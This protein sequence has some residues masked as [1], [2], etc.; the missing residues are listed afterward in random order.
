MH[1]FLIQPLSA[2]PTADAPKTPGADQA[3]PQ[4]EETGE[5]FSD[6]FQAATEDQAPET[7]PQ[8]K[9]EIKSKD[10]VAEADNAVAGV[11]GHDTPTKGEDVPDPEF[12]PTQTLKDGT[13]A[14][15]TASTATESAPL[16][17]EVKIAAAS[18]TPPQQSTQP[19][20]S[21]GARTA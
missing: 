16:P 11:Q 6:V 10:P 3:S 7:R 21:A 19:T 14:R 1:N 17:A 15:P 12:A 5:T 20:V 4:T 2:K 8:M 18:A 13:G 9:V